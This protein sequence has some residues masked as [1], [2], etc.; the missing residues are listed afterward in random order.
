[1]TVSKSLT[2]IVTFLPLLF[3]FTKIWKG[4]CATH[5]APITTTKQAQ[6]TYTTYNQKEHIEQA[7]AFQVASA[8]AV[9]VERRR[10]IK[11]LYGT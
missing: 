8:Q 5:E 10:S 11:G 7:T 1:M 6:T 9:M 3:P 2:Q 4:T